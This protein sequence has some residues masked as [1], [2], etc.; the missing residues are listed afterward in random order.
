M[1]L[2]LLIRRSSVRV[3]HAPPKNSVVGNQALASDR[4][5]FFSS[6]ARVCRRQK[7]AF[8]G[9][10]PERKNPDQAISTFRMESGNG[11]YQPAR[12]LLAR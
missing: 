4:G 3:T 5:A 1:S 9:K 7:L 12:R 11:I 6:I 2:G 8:V 10:L